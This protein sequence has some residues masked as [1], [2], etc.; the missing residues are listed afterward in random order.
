MI[1][2]YVEAASLCLVMVSSLI[3]GVLVG[4]G[5]GRL[6][7]VESVS[8]LPG[9]KLA[10]EIESLPE[11][12]DSAAPDVDSSAVIDDSPRHLREKREARVRRG[13]EPINKAE[14]QIITTKTNTERSTE[15]VKAREERLDKW[16]PGAKRGK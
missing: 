4:Y 6:R 1:E 15:A 13:E 10:M 2:F 9:S 14:S 16:M 7:A 12:D 11:V 8:Q 3:A 5:L